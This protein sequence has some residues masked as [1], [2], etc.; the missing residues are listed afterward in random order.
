MINSVRSKIH[1]MDIVRALAILAVV[2]IHSTSDATLEPTEG[3]LSQ[4]IFYAIN[5]AC[6]FAVPLFILISG[7]VLFYQYYDNWNGKLA[8]KYFRKR[9]WRV[10]FPYVVW[11]SFYYMF[12]QYIS[13]S[14]IKI[15][16]HEFFVSFQWGEIGY[17]LYFMILILQFYLLFPALMTL[18]KRWTWFRHCLIP[19]GFLIQGSFYVYKNWVKE[20]PHVSSLSPTYFAYFLIGGYLGVYCMLFKS[21]LKSNIIWILPVTFLSGS[22]YV[23]MLIESRYSN[24]LFENTPW[25]DISVLFYSVGIGVSFLWIGYL[26]INKSYAP[27][28]W[29]KSISKYSFGIYLIHPFLL[30]SY[31]NF[32][33]PPGAIWEYNLYTLFS[34]IIVFVGAWFLSYVYHELIKWMLMIYRK[35]STQS[36][37]S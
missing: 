30:S 32:Y 33:K 18:A 7:F 10:A 13:K 8:C 24:L 15:N 31:K 26:L 20:I 23:G 19:L 12:Y 9:L 35:R 34:F 11:S 2:L 6:Q 28:R 4:M 17:H 27:I 3:S 21:W 16:L 36:L 25:Y 5:R 14:G 22:I 1:E 37:Q 29:L